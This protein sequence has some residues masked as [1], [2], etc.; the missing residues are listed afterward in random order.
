MRD[1]RATFCA[2]AMVSRVSRDVDAGESPEGGLGRP[3]VGTTAQERRGRVYRHASCAQRGGGGVIRTNRRINVW[4]PA[5][6]LAGLAARDTL[7]PLYSDA[8]AW[9]RLATSV[10]TTREGSEVTSD[11]ELRIERQIQQGD[12]VGMVDSTRRFRCEGVDE[13]LSP[14]GTTLGYRAFVVRD[15]SLE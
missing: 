1:P 14:A 11:G 13:I 10:I 4:R 9:L 2:S 7:Q 15:V 12:V 8:R 6:A 5:Q 3:V